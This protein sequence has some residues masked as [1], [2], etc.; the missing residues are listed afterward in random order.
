MKE[1]TTLQQPQ[2]AMQ[3]QVESKDSNKNYTKPTLKKEESIPLLTGDL[4]CVY[5]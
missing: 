3:D 4:L 1:H 5:S 2:K